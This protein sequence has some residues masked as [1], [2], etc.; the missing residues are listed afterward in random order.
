VAVASV[1]RRDVPVEIHAMG[2]VQPYTTVRVK[3]QI[4]AQL[5]H[6]YFKEGDEVHRGQLLFKL[7]DRQILTSLHQAEGQ[8]G[9]DEA[10]LVRATGLATRDAQLFKAGVISKDSYDEILTQSQSLKAS[11]VAGRAALENQRVQAAYTSIYS[12]SEGRTGSLLVSPG[13]QVKANDDV[14]LVVINQVAPIYVEFAIPQHQLTEV[15]KQASSATLKVFALIPDVPASEPEVGELSFLDNVVNSA[16]GTIRLKGVFR[17]RDHRLWP[18]EF[19]DVILQLSI[20]K[21][22][23]VIPSAAIL[24]GQ[25]G[26]YV[27]VVGS[28]QRAEHRSVKVA[29]TVGSDSVIET[30]L[31]PGERVVTD[32][33]VRLEPNRPVEINNNTA[34]EGGQAPSTEPQHEAVANK[35]PGTGGKGQ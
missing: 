32:G 27:Y 14:P 15:R 20:Q 34:A 18:G 16:T 2:S 29:R 8:L 28:A 13:N 3:S 17:N 1:I 19:V 24:T 10:Q 23:V 11:V 25:Q 30:G 21:D 33:H 5:E 9:K 22:A 31:R 12:P 7:D 35:K 6:A 4:S 26:E